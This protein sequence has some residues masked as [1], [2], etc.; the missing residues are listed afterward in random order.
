MTKIEAVNEAVA[1]S[2]KANGE[3]RYA[4]YWPPNDNFPE[5][6]WTVEVR[7]PTLSTKCLV[8]YDGRLAYA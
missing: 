6:H 1:Q 7:K 8:A 3:A 4:V 2:Q 5:E